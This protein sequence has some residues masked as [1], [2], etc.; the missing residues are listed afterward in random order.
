M[1]EKL[2]NKEAEEEENWLRSANRI[3]LKSKN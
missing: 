1:N 3:E 2:K